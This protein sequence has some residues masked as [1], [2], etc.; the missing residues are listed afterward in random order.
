MKVT[1]TDLTYL[2]PVQSV[3]PYLMAR[4][5]HSSSRVPHLLSHVFKR[6]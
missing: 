1:P 3:Y 4:M 5:K 2:G 6:V